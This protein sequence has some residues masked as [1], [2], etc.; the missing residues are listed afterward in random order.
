[1]K[2]LELS[3]DDAIKYL[4]ENVEIHDNIELSY[5]RIYAEGE[6]LNKDFSEYFGKPGFKMLIS[7]NGESINSTIEVDFDEIRDD[8]IEFH[9]YPQDGGEETYVSI[10]DN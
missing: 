1:M 10:I 8:L 6:V 2:N 5:N 7:L 9:H 3:V 4:K